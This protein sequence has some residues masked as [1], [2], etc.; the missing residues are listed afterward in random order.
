MLSSSFKTVV[1]IAALPL[2]A[3]CGGGGGGSSPPSAPP[4]V[5]VRGVA[6]MGAPVVDAPVEV[7][8][9]GGRGR[10]NTNAMGQF[11][12]IVSGNAPC[13]LQV[14]LPSGL[15][16]QSFLAPSDVQANL[17]PLTTLMVEFLKA[18]AGDANTVAT[19]D[20]AISESFLRLLKNADFSREA[21]LVVS[22]YL[23]DTYGINVGTSFL[24]ET[25]VPPNA[26]GLDQS[27]SDRLLDLLAQR[28]AF[29]AQGVFQQVDR[30][31][32]AAL[33]N[34]LRALNADP[35]ATIDPNPQLAQACFNP[36]LDRVGTVT[37][38]RYRDVLNPI[39]IGDY[40]QH[41]EVLAPTVFEGK[42]TIK[43][44]VS[45]RGESVQ[46]FYTASENSRTLHGQMRK[47]NSADDSN[48]NAEPQNE[49]FE[50]LLY[51]PVVERTDFQLSA[52]Q[53]QSFVMN[54]TR[55]LTGRGPDGNPIDI[56]FATSETERVT[57][58]GREVVDVPAGQFTTCKFLI[59]RSL[60]D[61]AGA[62][63]RWVSTEGILI[64]QGALTPLNR[65]LVI[66]LQLLSGTLNGAAVK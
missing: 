62:E 12:F 10:G 63:V 54:S 3:S 46:Y 45:E 50:K 41:R 29:T 24:T 64:Q 32:L 18:R 1:W 43:A 59:D 36:T 11:D 20:L 56:R 65:E 21:A 25:I 33:G 60:T 52:N 55:F 61:D 27:E 4:S 66:A 48:S 31:A 23:R 39:L 35:K 7:F 2:L 51:N 58:L 47:V 37:Q 44:V 14:S 30:S 26:M 15:L 38:L 40:D 57:Y 22:R 5:S 42:N 6:A 16:F 9:Q 13:V 8:C 49:L 28:G 19:A 53:T 17:T 34:N